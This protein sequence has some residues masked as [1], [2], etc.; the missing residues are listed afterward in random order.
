[1]KLT[2]FVIAIRFDK[3]FTIIDNFGSIMDKIIHESDGVF[4]TKT[5]TDYHTFTD[6]RILQ[7]K[8]RNIKL[9]I[10]S[11]NFILEVTETKGVEEYFNICTKFFQNTIV[12]NIFK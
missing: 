3:N 12:D 1:M 11:E 10:N 5:F 9:T 8:K 4:K 6:T 7:D 2:G